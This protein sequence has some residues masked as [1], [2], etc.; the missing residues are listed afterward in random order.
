MAHQVRRNSNP[1][2]DV[3]AAAAA[4]GE[5]PAGSGN[6]RGPLLDTADLTDG[7]VRLGLPEGWAYRSVGA[8]GSIMSDGVATLG[9]QDGMAAVGVRTA[10]SN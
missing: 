7:K 8:T 3:Q 10:T 9:R 2:R 6:G 1:L 5:T 4:G